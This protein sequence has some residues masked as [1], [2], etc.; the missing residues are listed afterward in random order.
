MDEFESVDDAR[1]HQQDGAGQAIEI[2]AREQAHG[3]TP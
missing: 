1:F 2:R 3:A